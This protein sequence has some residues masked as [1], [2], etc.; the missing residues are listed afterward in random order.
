MEEMR[1]AYRV[2]T[3]KPEGR[4]P[5]ERPRHRW[6]YNIKMYWLRIGTGVWLL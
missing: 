2:L 1:G 6:E 3:G 4:R 5:H